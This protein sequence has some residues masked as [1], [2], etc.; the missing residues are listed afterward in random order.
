MT[1]RTVAVAT[2]AMVL[3]TSEGNAHRGREQARKHKVEKEELP[4]RVVED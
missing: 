4:R 2:I 1:R 3:G